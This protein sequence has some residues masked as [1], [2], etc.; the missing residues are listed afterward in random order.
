MDQ[1]VSPFMRKGTVKVTGHLLSCP[2]FPIC[3]SS[4][5]LMLNSYL[6]ILNL[7]ESHD[8]LTL[9][10]KSGRL[11]EPFYRGPEY[12]IRSRLRAENEELHASVSWWDYIIYLII[13]FFGCLFYWTFFVITQPHIASGQAWVDPATPFPISN[14]WLVACCNI[15][16]LVIYTFMLCWQWLN[17]DVRARISHI[18]GLLYFGQ[19]C[20]EHQIVIPLHERVS[21]LDLHKLCGPS[22][23]THCHSNPDTFIWYK[24]DSVWLNVVI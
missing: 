20:P 2:F 19:T 17:P 21:L 3:L 6:S 7:H 24:N 12:R 8:S 14:S 10:R 23:Q 18:L 5:A 13:Y 11:E 4:T 15:L 16:H 22:V 9:H 1:E